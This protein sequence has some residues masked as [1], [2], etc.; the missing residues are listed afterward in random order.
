[1]QCGKYNFDLSH[2]LVMGILNVTPDSF[3][4]GGQHYLLDDALRHAEQML[5][6][7]AKIIDVGGES[8]RPGA[9]AVELQQEIDRTIPVIEKITANLDVAV[10]IDTSKAAVMREAV[11]VGAGMINDV[12]ALQAEGALQVAAQ[13]DDSIAICLMHMQGQPRTMQ[14]NPTYDDVVEDVNNFLLQRIDCCKQAG[15]SSSRLVVDPGFGFGK[16]LSHNLQLLKNLERFLQTGCTVLAGI[17]R[18]SMIGALLDNAVAADRVVGSVA[19]ALIAYQKGARI[20]RVHDV[21]ETVDALKI[22]HAV[23]HA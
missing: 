23:M 2:P 17:S 21:K 22:A 1:M 18:K 9:S 20:I 16:T 10:S 15:I 14:Q 4:D 12:M 5:S 13:T 11:S 19:A 3:S 8:T 6:A 7:G